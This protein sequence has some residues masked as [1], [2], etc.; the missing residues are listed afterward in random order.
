MSSKKKL[1]DDKLTKGQEVITQS[2]Q[3]WRSDNP[4]GFMHSE[5]RYIVH[6]ILENGDRITNE[7]QPDGTWKKIEM[8]IDETPCESCDN[9]EE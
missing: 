5:R 8:P 2:W 7:L 4:M 3:S 6:Q 9:N 1:P